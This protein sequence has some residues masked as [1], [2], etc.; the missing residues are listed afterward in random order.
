MNS[1]VDAAPQLFS[2]TA[3]ARGGGPAT[4]QRDASLALQNVV[5]P[6]GT[7]KYAFAGATSTRQTTERNETDGGR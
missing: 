6:M 2:V 5:V 3:A 4:G 1:Q 7:A